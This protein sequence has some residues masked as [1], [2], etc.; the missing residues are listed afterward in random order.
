M[1][2]IDK[3]LKEAVEIK[4]RIHIF[5]KYSTFKD[6]KK[7]SRRSDHIMSSIQY[8]SDAEILK[9]ADKMET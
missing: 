5:Y 6:T 9:H 7:Q 2:D 3:D 1:I 8:K 4:D